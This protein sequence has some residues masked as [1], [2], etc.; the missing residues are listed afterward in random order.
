ML[1]FAACGVIEEVLISLAAIAGQKL[2]IIR[3]A[4]GGNKQIQVGR[5]QQ[6]NVVVAIEQMPD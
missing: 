3:I 5:V 6:I 4:A 2:L 1:H